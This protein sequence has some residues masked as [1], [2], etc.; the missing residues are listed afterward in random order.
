MWLL[1]AFVAAWFFRA[2]SNEPRRRLA[3]FG[4]GL[5]LVLAGYLLVML[6]WFARNISVFGAPLGPAGSKMLW[7]TNY[8]QI[9][10]YP[11]DTLTFSAWWGS[12][13]A[14]ILKARLW[15]LEINMGRT[16]AEQGEIFLLPLIGIALWHFR[17]DGRIQLAGLGWLLTFAAMTFAFPFAGARGGF[18]HS[19]A[20]F[21]P[22]W[23]ALA[24]LGLERIIEWGGRKRGWDVIQAGRIFRPALVVLAVL[25][26][27]VISWGRLSGT[28]QGWASE[29]NAYRHISA[30]LDK[31]GAAPQ[32]VVMVANPPGFYLASSNPSIAVPAGE[33]ETLLAVARRYEAVYL[34]LEEGSIPADLLS[35]YENPQDYP[36]LVFLGEVGTARIFL[37]RQH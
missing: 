5:L 37:I 24:P 1:L 22:L 17:K 15:A 23:W 33:V 10:A 14:A 6:P 25:L 9:F 34:V 32:D 13:V 20:A 12:G 16:L 26:T 19:G 4:L 29:Y 35:V 3:S 36:D 28:G 21:Q 31:N 11:A 27:V 8:D 7:L 2:P 18:F 30:E